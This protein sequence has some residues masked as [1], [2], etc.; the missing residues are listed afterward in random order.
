MWSGEQGWSHSSVC[1]GMQIASPQKLLCFESDTSSR[2]PVE[3]GRGGDTEKSA[4]VLGEVLYRTFSPSASLWWEW[5]IILIF[6]GKYK[7]CPSFDL[8]EHNGPVRSSRMTR[9]KSPSR[10]Y[11]LSFFWE[12][13]LEKVSLYHFV[14]H[15][16]FMK[17][18]HT[19][20]PGPWTRLNPSGPLFYLTP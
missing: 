1:T 15:K 8:Q 10:L 13:H 19:F 2:E 11:S 17:L 9:V 14:K 12:A 18:G 4:E 20:E 7:N 16:P 6:E 5:N 3:G